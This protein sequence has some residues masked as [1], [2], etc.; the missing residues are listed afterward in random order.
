MVAVGVA[1]ITV[2]LNAIANV[3]IKFAP[4]RR[5]AFQQL[6][7]TVF[8]LAGLLANV[9]IAVSLVLQSFSDEPVTRGSAVLI[10]VSVGTLVLCIV[11]YLLRKMVALQQVSACALERQVENTGGI[12]RIVEGLASRAEDE[13]NPKGPQAG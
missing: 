6:R 1:L 2:T 12:V 9:W 7:S 8:D 4:D 10:A 3:T 11:L 13:R 5:T